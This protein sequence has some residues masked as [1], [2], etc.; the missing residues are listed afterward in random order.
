MEKLQTWEKVT[1][2]I[3]AALGVSGIVYFIV[4]KKKSSTVSGTQPSPFI[5]GGM[6]QGC[7]YTTTTQPITP[8]NTTPTPAPSPTPA[9]VPHLPQPKVVHKTVVQTGK[10]KAHTA[11]PLSHPATAP[12]PYHKPVPKTKQGGSNV[13]SDA[14]NSLVKVATHVDI[15][16]PTYPDPTLKAIYSIIDFMVNNGGNQHDIT[17]L[18]S[19]YL[20]L[21]QPNDTVTPLWVLSNAAGAIVFWASAYPSDSANNAIVSTAYNNILGGGDVTT[22]TNGMLTAMG[23]ILAHASNIIPIGDSFQGY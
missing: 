1:I 2:G 9:P 10:S 6:P 13:L 23:A 22:N 16:L 21:L 20:G 15:G 18:K 17:V 7:L 4:K 12:T 14:I 5:C 11:S 3:V 8:N 19:W